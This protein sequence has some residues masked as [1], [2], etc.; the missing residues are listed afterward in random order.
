MILYQS[1]L[2]TLE[3]DPATDIL[4]VNWP[5]VQE[6]Y[7]PALEK[8][9]NVLVETIKHY[10][11]KKLLID[12][13]KAAVEVDEEAY[14]SFLVSFA[15]EL[16]KTRLRKVARIGTTDQTR[17]KL[18]NQTSEVTQISQAMAFQVFDNKSK[19]QAWLLA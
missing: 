19:A 15:H 17:E 5:D 2:I 14:Q 12:S 9:A 8:E 7:I 4:S 11:V 1:S 18:V 10:D 16:M 3:Y 13:S 6:V